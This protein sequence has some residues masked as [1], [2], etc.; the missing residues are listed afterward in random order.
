M[1]HGISQW[2]ADSLRYAIVN[3]LKNDTCNGRILMDH[4]GLGEATTLQEA[5]GVRQFS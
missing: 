2:N 4:D 5:A 1:Q 3:W